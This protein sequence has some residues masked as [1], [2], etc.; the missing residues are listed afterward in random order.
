MINNLNF[1]GPR[2]LF[3]TEI[4]FACHLVAWAYTRL[5]IFPVRAARLQGDGRRAA[6]AHP[7]CCEPLTLSC[8][9]SLL[10][11]LLAQVH[12]MKLTLYDAHLYLSLDPATAGDLNA[13]WT[14]FPLYL[15]ANACLG[16]LCVLHFYWYALFVRIL[17]K[18]FTRT[19]GAAHK[20]A[21]DEYEGVSGTDS[22][23]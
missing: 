10:S 14:P 17:I 15:P 1:E 4:T 5:Y 13:T 18:L 7:C 6:P 3:A 23:R 19:K 2:F 16:I 20:A 11:S 22:D 9:I 12:I 8:L 21:Q